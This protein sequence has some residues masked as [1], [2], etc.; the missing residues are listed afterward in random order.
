MIE[1]KRVLGKACIAKQTL[2]EHNQSYIPSHKTW[3]WL[4][5]IPWAP[6]PSP[7]H[8]PEKS[9]QVVSCYT[10]ENQAVTAHDMQDFMC[11]GPCSLS[12]LTGCLPCPSVHSLATLIS[13]LSCS[14]SFFL[15]WKLIFPLS[16]GHSAY[17][18]ILFSSEYLYPSGSIFFITFGGAGVVLSV[19][20]D[21]CKFQCI[22]LSSYNNVK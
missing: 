5:A 20:T 15:P 22:C 16:S 4:E 1:K 18:P 13:I 12:I 2:W 21:L 6:S 9:G 7:S 3:R 11:P 19:L 14:S 17:Y 8:P 10:K